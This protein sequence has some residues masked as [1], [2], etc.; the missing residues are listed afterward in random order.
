MQLGPV[1]VGGGVLWSQPGLPKV[2]PLDGCRWSPFRLDVRGAR[3]AQAGGGASVVVRSG[4]P[5]QAIQ[6]SGAGESPQVRVTGLGGRALDTSAGRMAVSADRRVRIM[7]VDTAAAHFTV[8][9]LDRAAPGTWRIEPLPGSAAITKV[10]KASDP[11]AARIKGRVARAG[12]R[13]VLTRRPWDDPRSGSASSTSPR[14]APGSSSGP[15]RRP[16]AACA[17]RPRP[18]APRTA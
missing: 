9:G 17:G 16:R 7:R 8:V 13:R 14:A 2:W 6:L 5:G 3:A 12:D 15:P 4:Q 10:G 18:G 11:A 1:S